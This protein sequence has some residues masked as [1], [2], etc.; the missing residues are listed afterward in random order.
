M[1][2]RK[3]N[4]VSAVDDT[5]EWLLKNENYARWIQDDD[6]LL[7]IQ[8]K[9][10][11][12][13]STLMKY[14]YE[15]IHISTVG[16]GLRLT[17]FFHARG[18]ELQKTPLGMFKSLLLQLYKEDSTA[19]TGT[20]KLFDK[21]S[22]DG[23]VGVKWDWTEKMLEELFSELICQI[24]KSKKVTIFAD[25]LDEAGE[26]AA[27]DLVT[28]LANLY[29]KVQRSNGIVKICFSSRHYPILP[30]KVA[31]NQKVV[32]E[33]ENGRGIQSFIR[34]EFEQ[35]LQDGGPIKSK[36][37][38]LKLE[39]DIAAKAN[40]VFQWVCLVLPIIFKADREAEPLS[41]IA[42]ILD[43][44]PKDLNDMYRYVLQGLISQKQ[45][46]SALKLF[47]WVCFA[48]RPLSIE[49]IRHA[50]AVVDCLPPPRLYNLKDS[51]EYVEHG[52]ETR[53]KALSGGLIEVRA[54]DLGTVVQVN[55]QTVR[56]FLLLEGFEILTGMK[57]SSSQ[58]QLLFRGSCHD[59][60]AR[61]CINY[62]WTEDVQQLPS[63][64][65]WDELPTS[66]TLPLVQYAVAALFWHASNAEQ[67]GFHQ[68]RLLEQFNYRYKQ[69][70]FKSV[71]LEQGVFSLWRSAGIIYCLRE[72]FGVLPSAGSTLLH[73]ASMANIQTAV[74]ILLGERAKVGEKDE[75][76]QQAI[77]YAARGGATEVSAILIK[78][79][80]SVLNAEDKNLITPLQIAARYYKSDVL[81]LLITNGAKIKYFD[82]T[83][84]WKVG[85]TRFD[86]EKSIRLLLE[87][88]AEFNAQSLESAAAI[89]NVQAV[90]L[91]L[92]EGTD[93]NA[94]SR[95]YGYAL[96]AAVH[97]NHHYV[98]VTLLQKGAEINAQGGEFGCALAAAAER[99]SE[100]MVNI[101]LDAGAEINAKGGKYANALAAAAQKGHEKVVNILLERGAEINTPSMVYGNALMAALHNGKEKVAML[102][103]GAGAET[104]AR[105]G[106]YTNALALAAR[107]NNVAVV[108]NLLN[109]KAKCG[110]FLDA[111][112]QGSMSQSLG[113]V[114]LV[115]AWMGR[116]DIVHGILAFIERGD[117]LWRDTRNILS[118]VRLDATGRM[119]IAK[120]NGYTALQL[121]ATAGH[122]RV[123]ARL[124]AAGANVDDI[125]PV[126]GGRTALQA[127]AENGHLTTVEL[128]LAARADVNATNSDGS[129]GGTALGAAAMNDHRE[130]VAKL[131]D[132]GADVNLITPGKIMY[133]ALEGAANFGHLE[134]VESLL[135]AGA[136]ANAGNSQHRG[137]TAL[138]SA[139]ANGHYK[140]VKRLL[141]SGADPNG[142]GS[143]YA[144][145]TVLQ[146]AA[147]SGNHK[148]VAKLLDAGAKVN[149]SSIWDGGGTALY[150][151]AL[152]G[153][154]EIVEIL[155]AAKA[156]VNIFSGNELN[157]PLRAATRHGHNEVAD[158]L[159]KAGAR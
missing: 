102:L 77:H 17:F 81:R 124:L 85:G 90:L 37:L 121:S 117:P 101:L 133:T 67:N 149:A 44:L 63:T 48:A 34:Q 7:W 18:T 132:A 153:H 66:N 143:L 152:A 105:S 61:S 141:S 14:I 147:K 88:A 16:A 87:D 74:K 27:N 24:S 32:V 71:I 106:I 115:A 123:V 129:C 70:P 22:E 119:E 110:P 65:T 112:E 15:K 23:M 86:I 128:L 50:M 52:M 159:R 20:R 49:E 75:L 54:H 95:G 11:A 155:I 68:T 131:L 36:K 96:V 104:N 9:A 13:K 64:K 60:L 69:R 98:A 58:E 43:K 10:G 125:P 46:T 91:L 144:E 142:I 30:E 140:I 158:I 21:N 51:S 79:S 107:R 47:R 92:A 135:A 33:H 113:V 127:A 137:L 55:H 26:A 82:K 42:K 57:T 5:C 3:E 111:L 118:A 40:G 122:S 130:V 76:G 89:G 83:N 29:E 73:I 6:G 150:E 62:L 109:S 100:K 53:I 25:A 134:I 157:T 38:S 116:L 2:F 35:N 39:G 19:R 114:L 138:K 93:V 108:Q 126:M 139:A 151:A 103:L 84:P 99:G 94:E 97:N 56:D 154:F 156:D 1:N 41:S 31:E 59:I 148:I 45:Q 120:Y 136:N 72:Y 78:K 80:K 145:Y 4:I 8:G 28:Y 12:G 146:A